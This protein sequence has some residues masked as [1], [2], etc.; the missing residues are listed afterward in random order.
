MDINLGNKGAV[1]EQIVGQMLRTIEPFYIEPCLYYWARV[2]S[3]ASS[4][5]D[6][7]LQHHAQVIPIEVKSG[8]TGSL[9]SLHYF[10]A[11]KKLSQAVRINS[12]VPS[13]ASIDFKTNTGN[14]VKYEL[15]SIPFYL[16]EQI[17]RLIEF[18]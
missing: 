11:E 6:Y 5:I 18:I 3:N 14:S 1:S 9:K 16:T 8:S 2:E 17:H 4:E 15:I 10:M 7:I 12:D 13:V